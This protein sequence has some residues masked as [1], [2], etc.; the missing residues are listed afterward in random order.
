MSRAITDITAERERQ[1]SVEG[2]THKHDDV[3]D[4]RDLA[5]AA[6]RRDLVRAGALIVAEIER[7]D[8]AAGAVSVEGPQRV[9]QT[10]VEGPDANCMQACIASLFGIP[11]EEA[12]VIRDDPLTTWTQQVRDWA[13]K[14][15][16]G[17]VTI[18][19]NEETFRAEFSAGYLIVAGYS[20][21]GRYHAV[22]YK[23]GEL[24]HD[25]HPDSSGVAMEYVD[26]FYPLFPGQ[27][28]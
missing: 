26:Y 16:Y 19:C 15:G 20:K 28:T 17:F 9:M 13:A 14:R 18:G 2:W 8:R 6:A 27:R 25:P 24:W 10:I 11:I 1:S 21:R 5:I 23:D 4:R 3:H 22:V 7:L 12:P